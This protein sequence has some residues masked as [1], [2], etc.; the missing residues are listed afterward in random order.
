MPRAFAVA[1]HPDD[2]EFL[3]AGTL[4]LLGQAGYE[5]H[6]MN[7]ADGCCG[8]T[9]HDREA[10]A[11]IRL[12]EGRR[13]AAL[14]GAVFHEPICHDLE[15]FYDRPTLVR[16]ASIMR[17]VSPE[18]LLV[19][20]PS[21]YMLDHEHACQLAVTAAFARG[22][23][24]FPVGPPR[25]PVDQPVTVYHAQP[26]GNHDPLGAPVTPGIYVD[27]ESVLDKKVAMLAEHQSQKRWLDES[28]GHDSYLAV[29][30]ELAA[31]LGEWSG[32]YTYAEGWRR[33]IHMGFCGPNDDPL[34]KALASYAFRPGEQ[35]VDIA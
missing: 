8:S 25:P 22:M 13:A 33:R 11:A 34:S 6:Y 32:R 31:E 23:P 15:I 26:Y 7:L 29:C 35:E 24:N 17:E 10:T 20:A 19:H 4:L 2:I 30:R 27:V 14:V 9:Q 18:I 5:L 1:A 21:D 12:E 3:M 16:L 28:Q